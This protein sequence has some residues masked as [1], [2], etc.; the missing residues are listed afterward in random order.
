MS[1]ALGPASSSLAPHTELSIPPASPPIRTNSTMLACAHARPDSVHHSCSNSLTCCQNALDPPLLRLSPVPESFHCPCFS[2]HSKSAN[3][4]SSKSPALPL[5]CRSH[6][7]NI[8]SIPRYQSAACTQFTYVHV[9]PHI[10]KHDEG[11]PNFILPSGSFLETLGVNPRGKQSQ[12]WPDRS[13]PD[14]WFASS[15]LGTRDRRRLTSLFQRASHS[16]RFRL[17][18]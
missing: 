9:L 10:H 14:F 11:Q 1:A 16:S 15:T 5:R 8:K 3:A 17:L 13:P 12:L 4:T 18:M 6:P 7:Q 2:R